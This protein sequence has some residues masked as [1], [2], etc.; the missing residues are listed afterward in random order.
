MQIEWV[1]LVDFRSYRTLSLTPAPHL[2]VL[3][4]P[5]LRARRISSR[6]SVSSLLGR[7]FR[8]AKAGDM[9]R[10][11]RG[12]APSW[13]A[14]SA[15][16]RRAAPFAARSRLARTARWGVSGEG[17][18]WA[19][20]MPFGWQD[21]AIVNGAPQARR[22]F[23]D[24]FAGKLYRGAPAARSAGIARSLARRNHLLQSG[25][26]GGTR[27]QRLEPWNEQL[28]AAR[29]GAGGAAA[30]RRSRRSSAEVR[31]PVSDAWPVRAQVELAVP[32]GRS[33]E[34]RRPQRSGGPRARLGEEVRRGQTLVGPHR[35]DLAI[36]V[37]GR[38]LRGL[39]LAR[40]AA[41]DG[42]GAAPGRGGAG[43]AGGWQPRPCCCWTTPCPSSIP[44]VAGARA[45]AHRRRR[46]R[47]F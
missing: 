27:R 45:R 32:V 38:D 6:G 29:P 18:A 8:G 24:G 23:I 36:A 9:A 10:L 47:S 15:A 33:G 44:S 13:A 5:T 40:A 30:G 41:A 17:C 42:A 19:R 28:A 35:D 43:G 37:D 11:G 14:R 1:Q 31:A 2:N 20:A 39:R 25:M 3:T 7:S 21:L 4:G 16:A 12:R 26:P 22:N 34:R 46:A